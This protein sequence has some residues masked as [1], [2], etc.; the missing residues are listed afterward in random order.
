[1]ID[2]KEI[3]MCSFSLNKT[4]YQTLL[5]LLKQ[6][7]ALSIGEIAKLVKLERSTVQKAISKLKDKDLVDRRQ[8]NLSG[9]GYHFIYAA[10][11][12]DE[13]KSELKTIVQGWHK[14]VI[15]AINEW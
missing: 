11:D 10:K 2:L 4:E 7:E 13:I 1:M 8:I 5:I 6:S 15:E 12:H 9:G 3:I 14:S